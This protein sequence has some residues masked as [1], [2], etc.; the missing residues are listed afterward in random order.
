MKY[1]RIV[2]DFAVDVRTEA[3][4]G[5]FTPEVVA[6]FVTVPDQ[7]EN[8][9][10]LVGGEWQAPTPPE[11]APT[12]EPT[13]EPIPIIGPIAFQMLFTIDEL[14]A[15]DAAKETDPVVRIFWNLLNDPR[16]DVVD[17]NLKTVQDGL[18]YLE[19]KGLIGAGRT[20]EILTGEVTK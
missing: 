18:R 20:Q 14:V 6:E 17:R 5:F 16:T 12:S 13:P 3:P 15:I 9:W 4:E 7:V 19:A 1:A 2:N 11:P 8:G 10:Q